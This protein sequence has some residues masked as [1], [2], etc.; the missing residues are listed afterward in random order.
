M[1]N[2]LASRAVGVF[3]STGPGEAQTLALA[4]RLRFRTEIAR[5]GVTLAPVPPSGR[6]RCGCHEEGAPSGASF[7]PARDM[8]HKRRDD[9]R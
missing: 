8:S 9:Q 1:P 4:G 7:A 3:R 2:D 5:K 6:R